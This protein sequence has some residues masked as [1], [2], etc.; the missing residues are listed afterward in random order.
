MGRGV[1]E[2]EDGRLVVLELQFSSHY[3]N[4][5]CEGCNV[6]IMGLDV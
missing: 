1:L 4:L 5:F 3:L 6:F 2:G